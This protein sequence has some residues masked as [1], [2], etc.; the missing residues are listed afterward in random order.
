[1][2]TIIRSPAISAQTR[3]I[4]RAAP[5]AGVKE[6]P[7]Q[8]VETPEQSAKPVPSP[9]VTTPAAPALFA[10]AVPVQQ[11]APAISPALE[12]ERNKQAQLEAER[13]LRQEMEAELKQAKLQ[14]E[15]SGFADGMARADEVVA[16][17]AGEQLKQL[18]AVAISLQQTRQSMLAS[19]EDFLV[20]L[21]FT[22]VCR[23]LGETAT[24][25][26]GVVQM[27]NQILAEFK[28]HDQLTIRLHPQDLELVQQLQASSELPVL[29]AQIVL[30]ADAAVTRGGSVVENATGSLDARLD[31]QVERLRDT[32]L[33]ARKHRETEA[34]AV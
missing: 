31:V 3:Q 23:I 1:M 15:K 30:R 26:Q 29:P 4:K 14:A 5:V 18:A 10:H 16:K 21:A 24:T 11:A 25:R 33:L 2:E 22:A 28:D 27:I 12:A 17:V 8:V 19:A 13:K 32:L 6:L 9:A 20:E 34:G 7:P